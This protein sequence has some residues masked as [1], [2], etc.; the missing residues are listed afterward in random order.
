VLLEA[1]AGNVI[2]AVYTLE[3]QTY[4]NLVSQRRGGAT[5]FYHFD[6][7]GSTAELTG[8]TGSVTD[9]YLYDSFGNILVLSGT[10]VNFYRYVGIF[11][12]QYDPDI[13]CYYVRSRYYDPASRRFLSRDP[14]QFLANPNGNFYKY[15]NNNSV[16]LNDPSG[17]QEPTCSADPCDTNPCK[18][19]CGCGKKKGMDLGDDAGVMCCD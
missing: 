2:Q 14:M 4:G 6:G 16:N 5:S 8:A 9:S 7:L 17:E 12:Y 15:S 19:P 11:G 18:D 1:S 10:S 3:P 13:A